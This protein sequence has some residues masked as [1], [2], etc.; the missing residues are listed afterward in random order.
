MKRF[1]DFWNR[2]IINK[3]IV[4]VSLVLVS[5]VIGLIV[6]VIKMPQ[7]S[8]IQ[9]FFMDLLPARPTPTFDV[10]SYLTPGAFAPEPGS[11]TG[12]TE[13]PPTLTELPPTPTL[14]FPTP[15]LDLPTPTLEIISPATLSPATIASCVP[16]N[17][18]KTGKVVEIIDG[19]TIKV[20]IDKLVYIIRYIG[21]TVPDVKTSADRA[22]AE[23][24]KLVYGKEITMIADVSDKDP[25]GR[26]LRY[27]KVGDNFINYELIA[28][29]WGSALD[30][31]PDSSCAQVFTSAESSAR[32]NK[33]GQWGL[34]TATPKP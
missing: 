21:V 4:M 25:R 7:G 6:L 32:G 11:Q 9:G 14:E 19:N 24:K 12:G 30:V 17:K 31:P 15:T 2:D 13:I 1:V 28:Q 33:L 26:L 34:S 18:P 29:G 23:N 20:L 3:L 5:G 22:T 27:V 8:S 16:A 10:N